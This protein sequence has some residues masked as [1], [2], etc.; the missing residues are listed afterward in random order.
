MRQF[1]TG[2]PLALRTHRIWSTS[3]RLVFTW[4]TER[5]YVRKYASTDCTGTLGETIK[6]KGGVSHIFYI[7]HSQWSIDS[8]QNRIATDQYPMTISRAHVSSHWG[9]VIY[10]EAVRWP[11]NCFTRS[12]SSYTFYTGKLIMHTYWTSMLWSIDSCQN[13]VSADQYHLTV[14]RARVLTH[15]GHVFFE[16]TRGQVT[17]FRRLQFFC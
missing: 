5:T 9:D 16:V 13:R 11:V 7:G 2:L 12:W 10:L 6:R 17:S 15:R 1:L 4:L 8:C 14:S 3:Y